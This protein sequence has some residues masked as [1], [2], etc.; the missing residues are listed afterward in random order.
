MKVEIFTGLVARQV[1]G[2]SMNYDLLGRCI[3][4]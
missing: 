1:S 4:Q 3:I 2:L